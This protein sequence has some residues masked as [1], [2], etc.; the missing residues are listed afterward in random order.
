MTIN[1]DTQQGFVQFL[2]PSPTLHITLP[3]K[4]WANRAT[5]A[6]FIFVKAF[7]PAQRAYILPAILFEKAWKQQRSPPLVG[8]CSALLPVFLY[9]RHA[10]YTINYQWHT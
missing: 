6:F 7:P 5:Q 4:T 3:V 1:F 8:R 9:K 2:I 10:S